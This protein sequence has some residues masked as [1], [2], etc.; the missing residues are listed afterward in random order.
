MREFD[1]EKVWAQNL[2]HDLNVTF[3]SEGLHLD[4]KSEDEKHYQSSWRLE[5]AG[6]NQVVRGDLQYGGQ[7]VEI[8]RPGLTEWFVNR[9]T[10][11]E[12]GFTLTHRPETAGEQLQLTVAIEGDLKITVSEDG[13]HAELQ[14]KTTEVKVLDYDKLRVWDATGRELTARMSAQKDGAKLQ[15]EVE[16]S[17]ASY[18]L[19]IDPTFTQE[20]FLKADNAEECDLFGFSVAVSGDTV[21]IGAPRESSS[22]T[23]DGSNNDALTAG[24]AY[25]FFWNGTA[26]IQQAFLKADDGM[27]LDQFGNSVAIS[28]DTIAVGSQLD[29]CEVDN[30]PNG[31]VDSGAVYVFERSGT[32]WSQQAFLKASNPK[33][34]DRFGTS[35][36]LSGNRLVIG[37]ERESSSSVTSPRM[38]T[39]PNEPEQFT[40]SSEVERHGAN[41]HLSKLTILA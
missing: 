33:P 18:P 22:P 7:R 3:D 19:T 9:P 32:T 26:W 17:H 12:H 30:D 31:I 8:V 38:T 5:S 15:L 11:L 10:G 20:A 6:N 34:S 39:L 24:A 13:Q 2:Q 35:L 41:K 29:N 36:A 1:S 16:D 37:A 21:V 23:S 14:D 4:V 25:V 27:T 40:C 28:G